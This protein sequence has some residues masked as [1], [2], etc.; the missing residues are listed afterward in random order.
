MLL[1]PAAR[2]RTISSLQSAPRLHT[3]I[4]AVAVAVLAGCGAGGD[5]GAGISTGGTDAV[6]PVINAGGSGNPNTVPL[7]PDEDCTGAS[8]ELAGGG[9]GVAPPGCGDGVLTSDEACD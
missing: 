4:G 7:L 3:F 6:G 8:C 2:G 9:E 1:P 5:D